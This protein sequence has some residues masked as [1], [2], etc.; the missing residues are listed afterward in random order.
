MAKKV[1]E[2]GMSYRVNSKRIKRV[3]RA[4]S[5][6]IATP[7]NVETCGD[8]RLLE[9]TAR[10]EIYYR[11]N[12]QGKGMNLK[13][14]SPKKDFSLFCDVDKAQSLGNQVNEISARLNLSVSC[15]P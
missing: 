1:V 14:C 13:L 5:L 15:R 6:C 7:L 8:D 4:Y 11:A 3:M 2:E 10:V 9:S 12:G